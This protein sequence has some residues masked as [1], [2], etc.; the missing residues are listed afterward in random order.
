[1]PAKGIMPMV[2]VLSFKAEESLRTGGRTC[3]GRDKGI[4][5]PELKCKKIAYGYLNYSLREGS[6]HEGPGE[7]QSE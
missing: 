6:I 2:S 5:I 4:S 1:M 7:P 3:R